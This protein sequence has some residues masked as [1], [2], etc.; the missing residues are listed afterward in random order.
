M[1]SV[2]LV[3]GGSGLAGKAIEWVIENDKSERFGKKEGEQW[4][5]LTS[6]D[7]DL[8]QKYPRLLVDPLTDWDI[9]D[10]HRKREDTKAIFEKYKPTHVIHLAALVGGVFKNMKYKLDMLRDNMLINDNVLD[11]SKEYNVKKLVSCLSTCIFPD[12][13]TYPIDETMVHN[14]PPH[15]S[16]FGYAYA[17]RMIDV[18]N[19][20]YN[21]QYG[22]N[23]T[24]VIPTNIFG[25]HDNYDLEGAHA[26]PGL[27]H[28]C[29]LAK[30][31]NTPFI[32][33]GT[34]KP[35]RQ[36]IYS[37][38][39]AKLFIWVLRE[40]QETEPII[41]SV[42]E[43]DEVSIKDLADAIVKAVG[44]EGDYIFDTTRAD[45]QYKKTA[46]NDKLL[47]Y[48]P[49]FEFTPFDVALK[50]SVEWLVENYETCRRGH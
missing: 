4:I 18:Q 19:K 6:K 1:S 2:I 8:R 9:I 12:K 5:F 31:N 7:G 21:E 48:L 43:K 50:E 49:D 35:L 38:D 40:Y 32:V 3:T 11:V 34:G 45:G 22:C 24:S 27:T 23:F 46:S 28:K 47:K 37:R 10:F 25:P 16:N 17:K 39:L 26:L 44:F 41:L 13:T 20:A 42:G 15:E 30:K 33:G 36:F 14:G 29:Y